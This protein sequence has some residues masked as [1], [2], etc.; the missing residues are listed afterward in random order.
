MNKDIEVLTLENLRRLVDSIRPPLDTLPVV[1]G[2]EFGETL[3]N[4][5]VELV[6]NYTRKWSFRLD[7]HWM[8]GKYRQ[9]E[10]GYLT[11]RCIPILRTE[12]LEED[13]SG[14]MDEYMPEKD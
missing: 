11:F 13:T 14:F 3:A 2:W 6:Q 8:I 10:Y 4:G 1:V 9:V 12:Y 5:M 7:W